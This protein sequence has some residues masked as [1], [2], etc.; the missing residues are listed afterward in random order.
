[1]ANAFSKLPD[2][3][4]YIF[5]TKKVNLAK[6]EKKERESLPANSL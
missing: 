4:R 5:G 6:N 3:L 1:M 2:I